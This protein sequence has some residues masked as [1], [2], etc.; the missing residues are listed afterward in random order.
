MVWKCPDRLDAPD[1]STMS[2]KQGHIHQLVRFDCV[3]PLL[4][5]HW[6]EALRDDN[7]IQAIAEGH[8]FGS[9]ARLHAGTADGE[10]CSAWALIIRP[11][12]VR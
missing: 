9:R 7:Q 4:H 8:V 10:V 12:V 6:K 2:E 3:F 5:S 11:L 1:Q